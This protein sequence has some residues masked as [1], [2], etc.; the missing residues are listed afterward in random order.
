VAAYALFAIAGLGIV[1][2]YFVRPA[3]ALDGA[4]ARR[5]WS[6]GMPLGLAALLLLVYTRLPI[7]MLTAFSSPSQIGI[8][9]AAYGLVRNL[10]IVAFTLSGALSPVFVQLATSDQ[11]RLRAAYT[12]ALRTTLL[13]L[14]PAA[15]G[16]A[17]LNGSLMLTLFGPAYG[18]S[19]PVLALGVW[20]LCFYT[21]SFVAQTLLAA[22]GRSTR[23][24]L[25]LG[26]GVLVDALLAL[27]LV[28]RLG[29]V[30]A[31]YAAVAG[32]LL[33]LT[34]VLAWTRS[35]INGRKL[36][37][38]LA[39]IGAS[40]FGMALLVFPLRHGP[41]WISVPAAVIA[42]LALLLLLRAVMPSEL[43]RAAAVLPMP[44]RLQSRL[45]RMVLRAD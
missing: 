26:I 12:V 21:V 6:V 23:W 35:A 38:A 15:A 22:Q 33:I 19:A 45:R 16:G 44:A 29:A 5:I 34:L 36:L 13:L 31:S 43:A 24:F 40:A 17:V 10:Q 9:N 2:R 11:E 14:L 8:F 32:D 37:A 25:A 4:L 30:G 27:L 41:I 1:F 42:Y 28:P 18:P 20:S 3:W 7:Y 39:R